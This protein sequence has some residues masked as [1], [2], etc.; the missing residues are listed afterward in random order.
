M[1]VL[2]GLDLAWSS[3]NPTG[4]VLLAPTSGGGF[5]VREHTRLGGDDELVPWVLERAGAGPAV[6]A[7]DAPL[8]APN[9]PGTSRPVD[10]E[11]TR[12]FARQHAGAYPGNRERCARPV[13][14]AARFCRRGWSVDPSVRGARRRVLLEVYP[15]AAGV[16]LFGLE[17]IVKY[18]KGP[19]EERRVGLARFQRLLHERLPRLDPPVRPF[20]RERVA[21]LRGRALKDLEDRLDAVVCAAMAAR[22]AHAPERCEVLGD[23]ATGYVV[24]P[25][26]ESGDGSVRARRRKG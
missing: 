5:E 2:I 19:V 14:L 6:V 23:V 11:V 18:K 20:P 25:R 3:R 16:R 15:H 26:D 13:E 24:V 9:P 17:R 21:E 8:V 10:R 4:A 12:L 22:F 7:V 1:T